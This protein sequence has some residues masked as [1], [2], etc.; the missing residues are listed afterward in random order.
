MTMEDAVA[1]EVIR[2]RTEHKNPV[3]APRHPRAARLLRRWAE[4]LER[5]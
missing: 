5:T 1:R 2:D 4:R 3:Q